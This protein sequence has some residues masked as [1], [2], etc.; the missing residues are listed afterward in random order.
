[1]VVKGRRA[2]MGAMAPP[3]A[4]RPVPPKR[5][6]QHRTNAGQAHLDRVVMPRH[7]HR[8]PH[9]RCNRDA[10]LAL[11]DRQPPLR[12]D[13]HRRSTLLLS[14]VTIALLEMLP[15]T[16]TLPRK[17]EAPTSV[18]S[19]LDRCELIDVERRDRR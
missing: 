2:A 12:R 1:M 16:A 10:P 5:E 18:R 9:G 17:L 6:S 14:P 3:A 7:D 15:P 8:A 19:S 13:A 4:T 11:G